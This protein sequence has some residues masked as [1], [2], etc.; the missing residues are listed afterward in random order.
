MDILDLLIRTLTYKRSVLELE[1]ENL[2]S[3]PDLG[4]YLEL[5]GK[6]AGL[7]IAITELYKLLSEITEWVQTMPCFYWCNPINLN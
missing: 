1:L 2:T 7:Q 3:Q 4:N 6:I 5:K